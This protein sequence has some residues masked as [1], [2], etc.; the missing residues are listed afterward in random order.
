MSRE[1]RRIVVAAVGGGELGSGGV[2]GEAERKD[3]RVGRVCRRMAR[4]WWSCG[5]EMDIVSAWMRGPEL[6][7]DGD[8]GIDVVLCGIV[9]KPP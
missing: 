8:G 3:E 9:R 7:G 1:A 5:R 4:D 2:G 6:A